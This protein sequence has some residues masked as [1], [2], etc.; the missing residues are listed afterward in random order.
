MASLETIIFI[1][2]VIEV[3]PEHRQSILNQL[4]KLIDD[5]KNHLVMRVA[6]WI[7]GEYSI[8]QSEIDQAF[9]SIQRNI[10]SLP[11]FNEPTEEE[12]KKTAPEENQ[13]PKVITK[14]I[15]LPDG[16]YGTETIVLD[17]PSAKNAAGV[18]SED[19]IPLRKALKNAEDDFLAS[20]IAISLTKMVVKCKKNLNIKKFN[21]MSVESSLIICALLK[22]SKKAVDMNNIQRMQLCLKILTT[23]SL[24][25]SLS[26]VQKILADQGKR[27]F[28]K[29]LESHSRLLK[30]NDAQEQSDQLIITQ[31][32]ERIV[33]RQLKGRAVITDF[34]ITEEISDALGDTLGYEDFLGDIK[35]D[36]D[37]KVYQ[38][39]GFSDAIYAEAFVEVHHYDILLKIVMMNRTNKTLPNINFELLTQGNLKVVEKPI[40]VTLKAQSTTT[41]KASLKVSSTDNGVIY[42]YITY[43]SASGN[44]PNIL[45]I[46]EIQIDFIND[47]MQAECS[48]LE[49][50]KKWAEY[51]WENK[52]VV[53]TTLTDLRE[54]VD[55]FSK[56]LN[57]S[58]MT[59]L[60]DSDNQASNSFMVANFY[61]KSKFEEDCLL[62][63][64]IEKVN[65]SNQNTKSSEVKITGL[66]RL[67]AKTEGMA[68]CVGEKCKLVR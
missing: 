25:K 46:N 34:D 15:I 54:F 16:S 59:K 64:S 57:V 49:F 43:D 26:G 66:I 22:G 28:Q 32:D 67:R 47:L 42:G 68:L 61:T 13:G 35:K 3:Y 40:P 33:F 41:I 7:I 27:I 58:L 4:F 19:H 60:E 52:V 24:L 37:S 45:N 18:Q 50:K 9:S 21:E 38:L 44:K 48:E 30:D 10:G 31:P 55:Y 63:M 29:F 36:I 8:S 39:T 12:Q 53:N 20:C 51:E 17:D 2:E 6:I 1:R 23:P 62:N 11:I 14:T 5:I 56:S 65:F